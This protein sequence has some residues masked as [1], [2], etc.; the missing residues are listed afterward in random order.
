MAGSIDWK[1]ARSRPVYE[2]RP[3][4]I[5][6]WN[7]SS[8]KVIGTVVRSCRAGRD[9]EEHVAE[10]DLGELEG[11]PVEVASSWSVT[12]T[13]W[14]GAVALASFSKSMRYGKQRSGA[15]KRSGPKP[16]GPIFWLGSLEKWAS[17]FCR[18][19]ARHRRFPCQRGGAGAGLALGQSGSMADNLRPYHT[20]VRRAV[21]SLESPDRSFSMSSSQSRH[22]ITARV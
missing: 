8:L 7:G 11:V 18:R 3:S 10:A 4:S 19:R 15:M 20:Q 22:P 9:G 21:R 16:A 5:S 2:S 1:T 17:T 12:T 13:R 6:T 14:A